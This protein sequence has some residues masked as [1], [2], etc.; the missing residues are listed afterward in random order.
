MHRRYP[1]IARGRSHPENRY[2][3]AGIS[4]QRKLK[5]CIDI[6]LICFSYSG[7]LGTMGSDQKQNTALAGARGRENCAIS[8]SLINRFDKTESTVF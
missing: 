8:I 2:N 7:P 1:L 5:T 6:E 3:L 4:L